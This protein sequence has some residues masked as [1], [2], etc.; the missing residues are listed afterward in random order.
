[1]SRLGRRRAVAV[2]EVPAVAGGPARPRPVELDSEG[3][4]PRSEEIPSAAWGAG[5]FWTGTLVLKVLSPVYASPPPE[6]ESA[7]VVDG[8]A[9][10]VSSTVSV[11]GV[12]LV[13]DAAV[14]EVVQVT[15]VVPLQFQP[16][17]LELWRL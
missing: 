7:R 9:A 14:V 6:T 5:T 11:M 16:L 2:A 12:K 17:P 13:P 1:M 8:W 3:T 10:A 4:L 15:V